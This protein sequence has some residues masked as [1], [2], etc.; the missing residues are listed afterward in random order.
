MKVLIFADLMYCHT[1]TVENTQAQYFD[2]LIFL[3]RVFTTMT[4]RLCIKFANT[5]ALL[6]AT[7]SEVV[8]V[9]SEQ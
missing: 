6:Q 3:K 7:V 5:D 1:V 9:L 8:L 4:I 2:N